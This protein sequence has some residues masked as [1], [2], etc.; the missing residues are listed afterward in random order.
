MEIWIVEDGGKKG[1]F[2]TYLLRERIEAGEL[3]GDEL[4]WH[5]DQ[6]G[7]VSLREMDVFRSAFVPAEGEKQAPLPP[8]LPVEPY[9]FI[10][11]FARWF[12]VLL[13]LLVFCFLL[14]C[15]GYQFLQ[16]LSSPSL[17]FYFLPY[18]LLEA[19]MLHRTG[20]SPGRYLLGVRITAADEQPL[21]LQTALIRS[22]RAFIVGLGLMVHPFLTG[23]CHVYCVWYLMRHNKAPWDKMT[24]TRVETKRLRVFPLIRFGLLFLTVGVLLIVVLLPTFREFLELAQEQLERAR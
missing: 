23:I 10:R 7:W 21:G 15:M 19:A 1:P 17:Y 22:L 12:D 4:A 16:V 13:Y 3:S 20:A 9:P 14:R 6:D 2:E 11:F 24:S 5:K 8:P 18:V